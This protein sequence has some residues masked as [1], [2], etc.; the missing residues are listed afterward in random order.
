[1]VRPLMEYASA[2]WDPY[3]IKDIQ[4]LEKVQHRAAHWVLNDYSYMSSGT[5]MLQ[6]LSWPTLKMRHKISRISILHKAIY[7]I[8]YHSLFHR[9]IYHQCEPLGNIIHYNLSF[10]VHQQH[11]TNKITL[12]EQ[13]MTGILCQPT[14]LKSIIITNSYLTYN[15]IS[16]TINLTIGN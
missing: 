11:H 5:S 2:V 8:N 7:I 9:T 15:H 10:L 14:L 12:Q 13:S 4:Q 16:L 3:Y 1:M 6:Q